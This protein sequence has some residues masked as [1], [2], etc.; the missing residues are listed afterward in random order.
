MIQVPLTQ[1]MLVALKSANET[2][3]TLVQAIAGVKTD[4]KGVVLS[5]NNNQTIAMTE[6]C[7]WHVRTDPKTGKVTAASKIW[8]DLIRTI[9]HAEEA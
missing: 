7:E 4:G 5:L 6:M 8:D 3:E 2:P 1:D 9:Q